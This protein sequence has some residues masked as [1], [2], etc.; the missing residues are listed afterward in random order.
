EEIEPY[1]RSL[2]FFRSKARSVH[3]AMKSI[4]DEFGGEV[5]RH[6]DDLLKLRGVARKTAN[7]VLGNAYGINEGI[8]VDTH[9][10]RLA[11]RF[12]L[13]KETDPRKIERDLM[14]LFP[15]DS[16]CDVSHMLIW[17]GRRVCKARGGLCH[18]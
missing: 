9:V 8:P 17:H 18:D 5:P 10:I 2:G 4:V 14:A 16:W 7:V 12:G 15:Q 6:M 1:I 13:S 11:G 3:E